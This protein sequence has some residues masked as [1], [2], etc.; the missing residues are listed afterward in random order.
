MNAVEPTV[1]AETS[2]R[3]S[4]AVWGAALAA[5][6]ATLFAATHVPTPEFV[7]GAMELNGDKLIHLSAYFVLTTLGLGFVRAAGW[8]QV[9]GLPVLAGVAVVMV[10]YGVFDE[11]TQPLVNRVCDV[12]DGVADTVGVL[13]A[14]GVSR[15]WWR[16]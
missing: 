7:A 10:G 5:Y 2:Q 6:W 14:I 13:A 8:R 15:G 11:I 4:V 3:S 16:A 12:L 9:L 1:P